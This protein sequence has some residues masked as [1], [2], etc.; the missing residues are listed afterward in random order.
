MQE[1]FEISS[2]SK[3]YP[4][5]IGYGVLENASLDGDIVFLVDSFFRN[6]EFFADK[7]CI[8]ID[9]NEQ[10]KSLENMPSI[11]V[12][13]KKLHSNKN[14]LFVVVGGGTLQDL[15]TFCASVYMRGVNWIYIPTTLLSMVD[16]C[17]GGKSSINVGNS[18]NLVGNF[19]PPDRIFIDP[20][21]L[22]TLPI[23]HL[24]GGAFEAEKICYAK[25]EKAYSDYL[26][27][28]SNESC[29]VEYDKLI[30]FSLK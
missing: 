28:F 2:S 27:L 4:I 18:K 1:F 15:G 12:K 20:Y 25:N 23:E 22:N 14:T 11:F 13:L 3:T 6:D 10:S 7:K 24:I 9:A 29:D 16:S 19:H 26:T 17:V 5:T 30:S 8:F 21:Y